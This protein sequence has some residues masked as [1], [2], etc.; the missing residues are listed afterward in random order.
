MKIMIIGYSGSGKSTLAEKLAKKYGVDVLYLDKVYWMPGWQP[1]PLEEKLK[2]VREFMDS[3]DGWVIDGN[4]GELEYGRR[5]EEADRLIFMDF[6]RFA[7]LGRA[8]RRYHK[9]KGSTRGSMTYGCNEKMDAKFAKW[10]FRD[11]RTRRH[12]QGYAD[13]VSR[14]RDKAIVIKNQRQLDRYYRSEGI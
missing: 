5:V 14:Y 4:G 13:I 6:N 10:V 8:L 7:C 12:R 1:R 11:S 9:Y 3:H 2:I